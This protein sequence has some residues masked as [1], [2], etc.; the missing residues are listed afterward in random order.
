MIILYNLS[1][2]LYSLLIRL[3]APF[4][5]K[6]RLLVNGR[7][8]WRQ[9]FLDKPLDEARPV[10]WFHA[11]SLG[12][13][14]QG[15]PVIEAFRTTYPACQIVLSFFSPSGYEVRKNY[16]G[17]DVVTYLPAD[18]AINAREWME[19]VRPQIAFFIKYEFW[20]HYL[21][22]LD[23]GHSARPGQ[24]VP[25]LSFSAI[26]RPNQLF[27]KPY[28]GFYRNLLTYFDHILVQNQES[29]TLLNQIGIDRV[30]LAGDTR[31][32][33]VAQV[34]AAKRAIPEAAAFVGNAP[35]LVVGSAWA[36]DMDVLIPALNAF[37]KPLR[38]IIA[39]HEIHETEINGWQ[40]KLTAPSVRFSSLSTTPP[41]PDAR[42]LFI[43]NIGMLTSLYQYGTFAYIGGAFSKG[44]HNCLE[45]ATFGLPLLFGPNHQKFQEAVD[46]VQQGGAF[47]VRSVTELTQTFARLYENAS[48]RER[49]GSICQRYV[50]GNVGA[51]DLVMEVVKAIQPFG[52]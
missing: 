10:A 14:E 31:F 22:A 5:Q 45:A 30:T 4:N 16:A 52:Q 21:Q 1:I 39:P 6:A 26:F 17:A 18:T 19:Q 48:E 46:L 37:T 47:Q 28:G 20:Y 38:V 44:L 33:R 51:T 36:A 11:A 50:M 7:N 12:E 40:S 24:S 13:F 25:T 32:D 8:R 27:F 3:A 34:A 35:T 43:D 29:V 41:P 42:Y 49:A 9:P 15:R 2:F 23:A